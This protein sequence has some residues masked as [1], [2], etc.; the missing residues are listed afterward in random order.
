ML[1]Q[2]RR[3]IGTVQRY[4]SA[5]SVAAIVADESAMPV[6]QR[7]PLAFP[8]LQT[9][10]QNSP[11]S[12]ARRPGLQET[13]PP[14]RS[15]RLLAAFVIAGLVLSTCELFVEVYWKSL[16][17]YEQSDFLAKT[18]G[19][20]RFVWDLRNGNKLD[21][22]G[23]PQSVV[24]VGGTPEWIWQ[25]PYEVD[26]LLPD[27]RELKTDSLLLTASIEGD[28]IRSLTIGGGTILSPND[29]RTKILEEVRLMRPNRLSDGADGVEAI[30]RWYGT[31]AKRDSGGAIWVVRGR[32]EIDARIIDMRGGTYI[33][34]YELSWY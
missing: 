21:A 24:D 34:Q 7:R 3:T 9:A 20:K 22:L 18:I 13:A 27:G 14:R 10:Q 6:T 26:I 15:G 32:P 2:R 19:R 31:P 29:V 23:K 25:G 1:P 16:N 8:M 33:I 5:I 17:A 30:T 4:H 12:S 11:E 28:E